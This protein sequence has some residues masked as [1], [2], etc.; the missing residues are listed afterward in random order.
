[1]GGDVVVLE[2][3]RGVLTLVWRHKSLNPW[4]LE[5]ADVD[6]DGKREIVVGVWKKSPKDPQMA[7]RVFV[8]LWNGQRLIPK[9]LGSRLGRRFDDFTVYD[10]NSDGCD[11]LLALE[12][13]PKGK[14][15]ISAYRWL[16]FGFEWIGC[17]RDIGGIEALSN[18]PQPIAL[19]SS[20]KQKIRY[21][22]GSIE[23]VE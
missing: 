3:R 16:S 6:G 5:V 15:R 14:N 4:K 10:I 2:T 18:D 20:S 23:V 7:K 11:E 22:N 17:S 1:M 12:K 19:T 8:Y 13:A 21:V 9:W